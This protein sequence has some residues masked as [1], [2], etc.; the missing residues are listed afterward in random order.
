MQKP[1]YAK[2]QLGSSAHADSWKT[3]KVTEWWT[4][5][6]KHSGLGLDQMSQQGVLAWAGYVEHQ[7]RTATRMCPSRD[8][9]EAVL[10]ATAAA[11]M[12]TSETTR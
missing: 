2:H 4:M 8:S 11:M 3:G 10:T 12:K 9:R 6:C 7:Y 5:W 1:L